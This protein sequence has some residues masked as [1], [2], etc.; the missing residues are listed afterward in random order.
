VVVAALLSAIAPGVG[1]LYAG[2]PW[3]GVALFVAMLIIV[4]AVIGV[5]FV[6]PASFAAFVAFAVGAVTVLL[7]VYLYAIV[8]AVRLARSGSRTAYRWYVHVAAIAGVYLVLE[9]LLL[10][11]SGALPSPPWR[12][13]G[14]S[15]PS[16]EPTLRSGEMVLVDVSYFGANP[17]NRGDVVIYRL[18]K[19][20]ET[21]GISRI[22]ALGGDRVAFRNGRGF[23]NGV[24]AREPY[25][26]PGDPNAPFNTLADFTVPANTVFVV[27]DNR[28]SSID[29]RDILG[30]GPV[31]LENLAGRATEILVTSLPDRAGLWVGT[32]R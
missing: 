5:A 32:P 2:R 9:V 16:M 24:A 19:D 4:A 20:P 1:Q 11:L 15:S 31:P 8:D 22:V 17:P 28:D 25:A 30:H 21:T 18:P 14:V 3:R 26:K 7:G 12:N 13:F 23:V 27:G 6:I 29:S 10:G